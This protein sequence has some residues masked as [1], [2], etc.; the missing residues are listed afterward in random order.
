MSPVSRRDLFALAAKATAVSALTP[1]FSIAAHAA[2]AP[3]TGPLLGSAANPRAYQHSLDQAF[4]FLNRMMDAY[5]AGSTVRL[6]QSY[7]AQ[8]LGATHSLMTTL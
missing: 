1:A 7:S 2:S 8:A 6:T 5:A 4:V 3:A